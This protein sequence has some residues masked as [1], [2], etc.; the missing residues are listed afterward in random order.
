[1]EGYGHKVYAKSVSYF[2]SVFIVYPHIFIHVLAL[3]TMNLSVC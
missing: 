1:M 2:I 3:P